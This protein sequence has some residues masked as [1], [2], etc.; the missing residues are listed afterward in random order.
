MNTNFPSH[1]NG[2]E[3]QCKYGYKRTHDGKTLP[4]IDGEPH[5]YYIRPDGNISSAAV[6]TPA[7][8]QMLAHIIAQQCDKHTR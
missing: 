7:Y 4:T 2:C 5:E 6:S 8:A 3:K 1:C